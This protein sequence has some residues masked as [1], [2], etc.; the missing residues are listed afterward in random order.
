M[1]RLIKVTAQATPR[2]RHKYNFFSKINLSGKWLQDAGFAVGEVVKV[3][4]TDNYIQIVK[5]QTEQ[6]KKGGENV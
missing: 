6:L 5:Q 3:V 2:A 4:T 1:E